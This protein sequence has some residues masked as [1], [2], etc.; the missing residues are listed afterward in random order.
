MAGSNATVRWLV[1]VPSLRLRVRA[2]A[3]AL[4]RQIRQIQTIEHSEPFEWL[5]GGELVLTTGLS[6]PPAGRERHDYVRRMAEAG[7]SALGFGVGLSFAEIPEDLLASAEQVGLAVLEVPRPTAFA[8]IARTVRDRIAASEYTAL[9]RAS[10]AQPRMTRA[11]VTGGATT[12]IRELATATGFQVALADRSGRI[13]VAYPSA[14]DPGA[15]ALAAEL[16]AGGHAATSAQDAAGRTVIVQAIGAIDVGHGHLVAVCPAPPDPVAQVLLGHATSLLALDRAK[17]E[18]LRADQTRLNGTALRL[19]LVGADAAPAELL[20]PA[21]GPDGRIRMLTVNAARPATVTAFVDALD[22][23]LAGRGRQLWAIADGGIARVLLRGTDDP[24][25]IEALTRARPSAGSDAPRLGLSR[26]HSVDGI[27]TAAQQ[28][29]LAAEG[30]TPG[31]RAIGIDDLAGGLLLRSPAT[32][33]VLA[34]LGA[35]LTAPL[36]HHDRDHGT[37]LSASLRAFLEANGNWETASAALGV[38]RHTLRTRIRRVEEV[39][40]YDVGSARV[41]AELLLAM[42]A[43]GP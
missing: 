33:D 40:G 10:R 37:E 3:G 15:A 16:A 4:D 1:S 38:H 14:L 20:E 6:L 29:D 22:A 21:A 7:V 36:R 8:A 27:R 26:P 2:G 12:L 5:V 41:R 18:R 11:V 32:R 28:S 23:G 30:A 35:Q 31:A 25:R 24:A 19:A 17:P 34:D 39:L 13:T 43:A 42:I 9:L